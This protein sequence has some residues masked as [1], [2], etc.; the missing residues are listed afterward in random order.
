MNRRI[1]EAWTDYRRK[2]LHKDA[3]PVQLIECR[4]AFFAGVETLFQIQN[5]AYDGST[6][7]PTEED[8]QILSDIQDEL[9]EFVTLVKAGCRVTDVVQ[10]L[11]VFKLEE[12]E[13]EWFVATDLADARAVVREYWAMVGYGPDDIED[14]LDESGEIDLQLCDDSASS[15]FH[16]RED[17]D[18][19][20]SLVGDGFYAE[21]PS[22]RGCVTETRTNAEHARLAGRGFWASTVY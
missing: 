6:P 18:D 21:C 3:P 13:T 15:T 5:S 19:V 9:Q 11:H 1:E 17:N 14:Y 2:V 4:R 16:H 22:E 12:G 10:Q 7:E 8:L 20:V